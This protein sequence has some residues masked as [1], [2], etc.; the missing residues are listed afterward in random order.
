MMAQAPAFKVYD[1][2]GVY[3]A[4]CKEPEAA[5]SLMGLYG[6][7]STVRYGHSVRSIVWR[8]GVEHDGEAY[9]SWDEA[10]ITMMRRVEGFHGAF[11]RST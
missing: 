5:A 4:A 3:Q 10:A 6:P 11:T 9:D 1:A 8:E 7:G 2:N